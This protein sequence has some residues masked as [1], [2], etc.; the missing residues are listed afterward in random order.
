MTTAACGAKR[1]PAISQIPPLN[2]GVSSRIRR[3]VPDVG[4]FRPDELDKMT[5]TTDLVEYLARYGVYAKSTRFDVR[6]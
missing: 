1:K 4:W 5:L 6:P 3:L 2:M